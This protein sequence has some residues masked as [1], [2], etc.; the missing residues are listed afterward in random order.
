M[1]AG[2]QGSRLWPLSR[3]ILPK[4][5]I[6]TGGKPSLF[7]NTIS[8]IAP[9][10]S[11]ENI[12]VAASQDHTLS[13][14]YNQLKG[15]TVIAEPQSKNTAP[16][17]A[18]CSLYALRKNPHA[19]IAAMPADQSIKN[20]ANFRRAIK[21]AV[22]CAQKGR[23]V[24]L[25]IKPDRPETGYGYIEVN[26]PAKFFH[27]SALPVK[28]F[29]EKPDIKT[30]GAYLK[31]G[32]YFWNAG[33]FVFR[34][35]VMLNEIKRHIPQIYKALEKF[36][37]I[38]DINEIFP[39]MPNI[40][41]DYAVMEKSSAVSVVP[42]DMG[43]SDV[44]SWRWFYEASQKD[45][46]KNAVF[47]D[48]ISQKCSGNL[49]HSSTR[50]VAAVGLK[51]TAVVETEDAV[52][53]CPLNYSQEVRELAKELK[54]KRKS[55]FYEHPTVYKPWGCYT[56]FTQSPGYK[57][58]C[59]AVNPGQ[60]LSFQSHK[61]RNEHWVV[62]KG[63]AEIRLGGKK[64]TLSQN[65]TAYVPKGAKHSIANNGRTELKVIEV[66]TGGYL[67]ED[68]IKRFEDIYGRITVK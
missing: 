3:Q 62:A 5:F 14:A 41:I 16:A 22:A 6:K 51:D 59:I 9:L 40:S 24:T 10:V 26:S 57:V 32:R 49:L 33:I 25:G 54:V 44:G 21:A 31:S 67:G 4:Q 66:Q 36:N 56:V 52:L 48:V 29:V 37:S 34:A 50:L 58:K 11:R 53:V 20:S 8:R 27:R 30:A 28:K 18:V 39:K 7:E 23:I 45:K 55:Q 12:I 63:S 19:V 65:Q 60:R 46:S 2:G 17:I 47:G 43:W 68:D 42:C 61:S 1:L 15:Y 64:F 35:D 38:A 13:S